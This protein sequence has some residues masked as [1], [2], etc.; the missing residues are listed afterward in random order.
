MSVTIIGGTSAVVADVDANKNLYVIPGLPAHPI[1]GGW[2]SVTGGPAGIVA[3]ALAT[4]TPLMAMRLQ[5]ASTRKAYI[6]RIEVSFAGAT[7]GV[8]AGVAGVLGIQ[9]FTGGVGSTGT[10][11]VVNE[12]Y[13]ALT[14]ATDV[15]S[16]QDKASALTMT[17]VAYGAE[18]AWVR[19]A[20]YINGSM[21]NI[22]TFN[23]DYPLVLAAGDGIC[24]RTRV[25]CAATQT[26]VFAYTVYWR[27]L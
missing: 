11:R 24:L 26:W 4:D 18:V 19:Q 12:M 25:Q 2:Y 23:P 20:L 8:S 17:N 27:E 21:W 16:V 1:A 22:Y 5:A 3:A 7:I 13:E 14:T 15:T 10:E 9:R 6:T